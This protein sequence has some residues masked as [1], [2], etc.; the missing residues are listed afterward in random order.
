MNLYFQFLTQNQSIDAIEMILLPAL[1]QPAQP[2]G[3][4]LKV[5]KEG[6]YAPLSFPTLKRLPSGA[7]RHASKSWK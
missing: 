7:Q 4:R 2:L 1:L 5:S 6:W 3:G